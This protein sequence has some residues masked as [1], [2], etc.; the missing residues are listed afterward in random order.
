MALTELP[1]QFSAVYLT[2]IPCTG[3]N[4]CLAMMDL[5][6][7]LCHFLHPRE[8]QCVVQLCMKKEGGAEMGQ[9]KVTGSE[10]PSL[11]FIIIIFYYHYY[12]YFFLL[13]IDSVRE[14]TSFCN[15]LRTLGK[16]AYWS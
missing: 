1:L 7:G 12:Y 9:E 10:S 16:A 14:G 6:N 2:T 5:R 11:F 8:T 13:V 4:F 15:Q 3:F